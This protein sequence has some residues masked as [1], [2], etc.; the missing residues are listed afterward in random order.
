[1]KNKTST[2]SSL[3]AVLFDLDGTLLDTAQDLAQALNHLL[4]EEGKTPLPFEQIRQV[5]SNGG[6]AMVSLGF[7]TKPDTEEHQSLYQRLLDIYGQQL[8]NHTAP[9]P[10]I[11]PLLSTLDQFDLPWGV[12]TNKPSIYSLPIMAQMKFDPPCSALVCA[13]QVSE[14]KP[15]PESMLR[16]CQLIGCDPKRTLYVG[17]HQ[18]DIEAGR[19]AGMITIAALYGY[20]DTDE[21]P[22]SWG[23][24]YYIDHPDELTQLLHTHF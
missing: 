20:I 16:A 19:N 23:A 2:Q 22:Q 14:R 18:R 13:D 21:D 9:F 11:V 17:D 7:G 1:M 8:T 4:T 15:H 10:G 6:N 3:A 5:V 24:D 12:V